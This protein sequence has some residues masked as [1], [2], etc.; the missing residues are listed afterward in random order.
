MLRPKQ[1]IVDLFLV[2]GLLLGGALITLTELSFGNGYTLQHAPLF[3]VLGGSLAALAGIMK[4]DVAGIFISRKAPDGW[5]Y[6]RSISLGILGGLSFAGVMHII[7]PRAHHSSAWFIA[8]A[9]VMAL[10]HTSTMLWDARR[11]AKNGSKA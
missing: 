9:S 6:K 10:I 3:F 1:I 11:P 5:I 4:P 7:L 2:K 8:V